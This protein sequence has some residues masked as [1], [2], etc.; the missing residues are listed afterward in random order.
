VV[1]GFEV[2]TDAL[3]QRFQAAQ[4]APIEVDGQT[5]QMIYEPPPSE[6]ARLEIELETSS[7]HVQGVRIKARGGEVVINDQ[8][9]DDVVLWT[10]TA[11]PVT[12]ADVR[13]KGS[14][15]VSVRM[16]NVW[17]NEGGTMQAWIGD[18]GIVVEDD[19]SGTALLRCSDGYDEP[20]FDD[21][22]VRLRLGPGA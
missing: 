20:S 15:P 18:A 12:T 19:G 4:G 6:P 16:W 13:A 11:P 3:A 2:N 8:A 5:A 14:K 9:L 1:P 17:R 10:D 22:I 7:S 21:L